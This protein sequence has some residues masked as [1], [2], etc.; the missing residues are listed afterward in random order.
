[1]QKNMKCKNMM[2]EQQIVHLPKNRSPQELFEYI[3]TRLKPDKYA[4]IVHDQDINDDGDPVEPHVHVM[5]SFSNA[6]YLTSIAKDLDELDQHGKPKTQQITHW[7]RNEEN[8][9]AYLIHKT[10]NTR[11]KY[12][13]DEK[14]VLASFDFHAYMVNFSINETSKNN[15]VNIKQLLDALYMGL[16][17]KEDVEKQ[18]TGSQYGIHR[19]QIEAVNMKRLEKEAEEWRNEAIAEGKKTTVFWIFGDSGTG[20]TSFAK[21]YAASINNSYFFTG[22]TKDMFQKYNGEHV[23]II[24]EFRPNSIKYSDL[25]RMLDPCGIDTKPMAPSRFYD[26]ALAVDYFIITSPYSPKAF[27]EKQKHLDRKIDTFEQ[28]LRRISLT[29]KMSDDYIT[30]CEYDISRDSMKEY[31]NTAQKNNYSAKARQT[32]SCRN[33]MDLFNSI[34][35]KKDGEKDEQRNTDDADDS[36]SV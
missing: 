9:Y 14:D 10:K 5:M 28:L 18:L 29:I 34:F 19:N 1:M 15:K 35:M 30:Y 13:Y 8:G 3:G 7:N 12:Q 22:S 21:E 20:K 26:K 36:S 2:Y 4:L 31:K 24:D 33:S 17:S 32:A 6:R 23:V 25:L 11:E 27:Y 16:I